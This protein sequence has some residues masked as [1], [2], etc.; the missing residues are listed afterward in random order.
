MAPSKRVQV[1]LRP[2]VYEIVN[3]LAEQDNITLS[4]TCGIL[5]EAALAQRSL[6]DATTRKR[7]KPEMTQDPH[8]RSVNKTDIL[9]SVPENRTTE[10]VTKK[11]EPLTN[12][13]ELDPEL[14]A[15]AKKLQALKSLDL[16]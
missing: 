1:M 3:D 16:F 9:D 10:L 13:T 5:V 15:L 12:D 14:L 4:K 11:A 2:E 6:W 8:Y 7:I